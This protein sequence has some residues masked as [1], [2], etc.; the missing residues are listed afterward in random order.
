MTKFIKMQ[1]LLIISLPLL[2]I[3]LLNCNDPAGSSSG[4]Y[5][6]RVINSRT[7]PI[8]VVIGPANYGTIASND[9][10]DYKEVNE[11]DNE[12][13]LNEEVFERSP[14]NFGTGPNN[15]RWTY[16]F[17]ENFSGFALDDC[18]Y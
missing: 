7:D 6:V 10:T 11:G 18:N 12:I 8:T 9:T 13:L 3:S 16:E 17:G 15:C 14:A 5:L 1:G 4:T 2:L